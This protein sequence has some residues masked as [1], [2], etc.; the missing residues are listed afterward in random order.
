LGGKDIRTNR[1]DFSGKVLETKLV[2]QNPG[3]TDVPVSQVFVYDHAG[4]LQE[5]RQSTSQEAEEVITR[6]AYNELGQLQTKQLGNNQQ[7][8]DYSYNIRGWLTGINDANLTN[9]ND[10]FGLELSYDQG[11]EKQ[12]FN[13]NISGIRWKSHRDNVQRA[14]GYHYDSLN[15]I[16][17]ADFRSLEPTSNL[18]T[19]EQVLDQGNFDVSGIGYDGNGNILSMQRFGLT[20]ILSGQRQYGPLDQLR[21]AYQGNQLKAVDDEYLT[22]YNK[23]DFEDNGSKYDGNSAEYAYDANGNLTSDQNKGITG[24]AYNHLSLPSHISFGEKGSME[25]VYSAS[26]S[27]LRKIVREAGKP[28]AIT[29]YVWIFV[30]QNDTL[31][32]AHTAEGR[33][34]FRP[35]NSLREWVYEYHYK[36][37]LGNTRLA[38]R[39]QEH[40]VKIATME[41]SRIAEEQQDFDNI[42]KTRSPDR[43]YNGNYSSRLSAAENKPLGPLT[44][45]PVQRGDSL[46]MS[47]FASYQVKAPSGKTWALAACF[48]SVQIG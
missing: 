25:F 21:Y 6:Q 45:L 39:K 41:P 19:A 38:F 26:G 15:R 10:L 34:L 48:Q 22:P 36:D 37:Q 12:Y 28:D 2:H 27:K 4:R 30:Y 1:Y 20:S 33:V 8:L 5:T 9:P 42:A 18:W 29:D 35:Q 24:I 31:Q 7:Q 44:M 16:R 13:G 11:F 40:E 43:S 17:Q 47:S 14:Y 3:K 23:G 32:F 46:T